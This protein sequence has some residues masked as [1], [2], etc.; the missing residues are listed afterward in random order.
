MRGRT[1]PRDRGTTMDDVRAG[2]GS[3]I[4]ELADRFE[5]AWAAGERPRIEDYLGDAAGP[6][7]SRLLGELVRVERQLRIA[8]GEAPGVAEYRRRFPGHAAAID[9]AFGT[10]PT[11][12]RPR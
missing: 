9:L 5:R 8:G 6:G 1:G 10:G 2:D 3:W 4:D 12:P 7:R 11:A